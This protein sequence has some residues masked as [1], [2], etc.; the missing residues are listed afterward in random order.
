MMIVYGVIYSNYDPWEV[1][2]L[3]KHKDH[4]EHHCA[5]KNADALVNGPSGS[6]NWEVKEMVVIEKLEEE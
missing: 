1:D 3:W 5:E 6:D 2:S 4:A